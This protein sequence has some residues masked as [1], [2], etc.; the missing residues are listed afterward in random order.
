MTHTDLRRLHAAATPTPYFIVPERDNPYH[1]R[2]DAYIAY[3]EEGNGQET[4]DLI[5][6]YNVD[7]DYAYLVAAANAVPEL[8][9]EVEAL[10]AALTASREET[11]VLREATRAAYEFLRE[12][13]SVSV[14]D[15]IHF[16]QLHS[17]VVERLRAALASAPEGT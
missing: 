2:M 11:R 15:I 10:T 8:L 14:R 6:S 13:T 12:D 9:D 5:D 7:T 4:Y 1:G 3:G 17:D 16:D